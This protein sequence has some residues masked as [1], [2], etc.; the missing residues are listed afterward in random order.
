MKQ[1]LKNMIRSKKFKRGVN[2]CS[3]ILNTVV[4]LQQNLKPVNVLH[5]GLKIADTVLS[6]QEASKTWCDGF[7]HISVGFLESQII[8]CLE[9]K[10][11][12]K[13]T[14]DLNDSGL[15][16]FEFSCGEFRFVWSESDDRAVDAIYVNNSDTKLAKKILSDVLWESL[17]S[18]VIT[19]REN[20]S[21][22]TV[23]KDL[24]DQTP[25]HS[26]VAD[27]AWRRSEPMIEA[28][29]N[30]SILFH[31]P[32]GTG[33]SSAARQVASLVGKRVVRVGSK[34]IGDLTVLQ[35]VVAFLSPDAIIV[36]DIDRISDSF[37]ETF[38]ELKVL[39]PIVGTL[40]SMSD[41]DQALRR[42]G[43]FDEIVFVEFLDQG[44]LGPMLKNVPE[45]D[46]KRL[47]LLPA[48]YI[49]RYLDISKFLSQD[50]ATLELPA[51]ESRCSGI[52]KTFSKDEEG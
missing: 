9:S 28:G 47:A 23:E 7:T 51:L 6:Q 10:G 26:E 15:P 32:P 5:S 40:N 48:A 12:R 8:E 24:S 4:E 18:C 34:V 19:L 3:E 21:W 45:D 33:K 16:I 39:A 13:Y 35:R 43:R 31:G 1:R 25:Y 11:L 41:I 22:P 37:L 50:E 42:P 27:E 14:G 46:A 52:N 36:D 29:H 30:T 17:E 20:Q 44:I 2:L 38:D 49:K